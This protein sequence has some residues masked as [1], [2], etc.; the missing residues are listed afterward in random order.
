M[1]EVKDEGSFTPPTP[2]QLLAVLGQLQGLSDEDRE[3]L[4]KELMQRVAGGSPATPPVVEDGGFSSQFLI[5]SSLLLLIA[6]IFGAD[7]GN[8]RYKALRIDLDFWESDFFW[9]YITDVEC[10]HHEETINIIS[11][12]DDT[13]VVIR[14]GEG[15]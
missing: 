9:L 2:E 8:M 15:H 12:F 11:G 10:V 5:L 6:L 14:M 7:T 3:E 4:K 1:E 13:F